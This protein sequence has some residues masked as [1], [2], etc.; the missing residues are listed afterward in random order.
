MGKTRPAEPQYRWSQISNSIRKGPIQESMGTISFDG[1]EEVCCDMD[2][3]ELME[4]AEV[5]G[6]E[7]RLMKNRRRLN[8]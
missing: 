8:L 6:W 1:P 7:K 4:K 5:E 2:D 3:G